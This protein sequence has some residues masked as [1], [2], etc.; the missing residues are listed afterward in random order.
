MRGFGFRGFGCRGLGFRGLGCR[1]LGLSVE[2]LRG[3]GLSLGVLFWVLFAKLRT[4]NNIHVWL[5]GSNDGISS[6][7]L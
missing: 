7:Y 5:S 2:G 4:Y 6:F 3:L 1:G